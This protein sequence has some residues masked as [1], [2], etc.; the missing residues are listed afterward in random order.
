VRGAVPPDLLA[1]MREVFE[2]L[3]PE[4]AYPPSGDGIVRELVGLA[5]AYPPLGAIAAD[6]RLGALVGEAL[7]A[8]RV[9]LLQD[10][11]LYKP[12]HEGGSVSWHQDHT[13]VGFLVPAR[14]VAL[15]IAL[16]PEDDENGCMRVVDG[17]HA[18]GPVGDTKALRESSVASL[19][20]S[21]TD[22]QRAGLVAARSLVL[23]P[24]DIS[25]H[26]CLT[27][28]GSPRNTS[29]R[30]RKTLILRMFDGACRL[31]ESKLPEGYAAYF[32]RAS[33]GTMDPTAFP[34]THGR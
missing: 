14:V 10:S 16:V 18:W 9:Q 11:L 31:D 8:D 15:R 26:H 22:E 27:V 7:G 21:L 23:E 5:R 24:G 6:R 30:T 4:L 20:P 12:P 33:D 1:A 19:E 29:A 32:P 17:S 13:Y 2:T 34:V 3:V 28:H 25:I